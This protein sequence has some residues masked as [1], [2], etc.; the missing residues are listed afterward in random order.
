MVYDMYTVYNVCKKPTHG[1]GG[2]F[3]GCESGGG[4]SGGGG[5]AGGGSA[6]KP[7]GG[8]GE[9]LAD[10]VLAVEYDGTVSG[11]TVST[12]NGIED[13]TL[14]DASKSVDSRYP[15]GDAELGVVVDKGGFTGEVQLAPIRTIDS[16]YRGP[17]FTGVDPSGSQVTF[18]GSQVRH[19][20]GYGAE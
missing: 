19:V 12:P 6:N 18:K 9:D 20:W 16:A 11:D 10:K 13:Q 17:E 7:E 15:A 1:K 4:S 14:R 8:S 2:R 5:G 3:T